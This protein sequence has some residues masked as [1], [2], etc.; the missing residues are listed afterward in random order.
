LG[1]SEAGTRG[2]EFSIASISHA[3][4]D[5]SSNVRIYFPIIFFKCSL[6]L[7]TAASQSPPK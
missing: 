4:V 6:A 1:S 2:L 3:K 7:F 5:S